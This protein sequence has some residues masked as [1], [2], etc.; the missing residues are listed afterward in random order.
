MEFETARQLMVSRQLMG[1]DIRDTMVLE[2]MRTVPRHIFLP[3]DRQ[4]DAYDDCALPIGDGQTISQ[5]YIVALM[6][7]MLE[8]KGSEKVLEI[9]TGSGYQTAVLAELA[10]RVCTIE[11]IGSLQ[12]GAREALG[13]AGYTNVEMLVGDGTLGWPEEAPFDRIIITAATPEVPEP[14]LEQLSD[15]GVLV[16]PVGSMTSQQLIRLRKQGG[17]LV[18]ELGIFCMFVPL[19]GEHGWETS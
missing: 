15:G 4:E 19:I 13:K 12:A 18:T 6:T 10:A 3:P 2:A 5:P 11:R 16:A 1:R 8:L 14:L 7:E 9:G 17:T